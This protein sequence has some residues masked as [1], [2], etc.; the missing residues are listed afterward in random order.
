MDWSRILSKQGEPIGRLAYSMATI[1]ML[2]CLFD[3]AGSLTSHARVD[4]AFNLFFLSICLL[5]W[6]LLTLRRLIE[7]R[8]SRLWILPILLPIAV[9]FFCAFKGWPIALR[10]TNLVAFSVQLPLMFLPPLK[11]LDATQ[12][13]GPVGSHP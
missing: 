8:A 6:P 4:F 13:E 3:F 11:E 7:I 2:E 12:V 1:L 9:G 10:I 5:V